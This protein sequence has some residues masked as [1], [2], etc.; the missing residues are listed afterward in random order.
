V[1][2]QSVVNRATLEEVIGNKYPGD[3]ISLLLERDG[4]RIETNLILTN[5]EGGT[6]V[7]ERE[8]YFAKRLQARLERVSKVEKNAYDIKTG[9]KVVDYESGGFFDR[10]DIPEGFIVTQI[11]NVPIEEPQELEDI[12][13]RIEGRVRIYGV[14][15]RGRKVYYP[16]WF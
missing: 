16:F 6:G 4:E 9:V 10:L 7:I 2:G 8:I 3:K 5:R 15:Q 11:N 1:E 13:S 12:L 14:D